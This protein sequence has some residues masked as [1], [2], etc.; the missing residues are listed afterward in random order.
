MKIRHKRYRNYKKTLKSKNK[1]MKILKKNMILKVFYLQ[2][3][4]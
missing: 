3:N 1:I 4:F 2:I